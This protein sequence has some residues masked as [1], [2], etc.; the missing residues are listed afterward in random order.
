M[1]RIAVRVTL[2]ATVA[3]LSAAGAAPARNLERVVGRAWEAPWPDGQVPLGHGFPV[4]PGLILTNA[5]TVAACRLLTVE[6]GHG[7]QPGRVVGL[8]ARIDAALVRVASTGGSFAFA[9]APA[10]GEPVTVLTSRAEPAGP[11]ESVQGRTAAGLRNI[12]ASN[13]VEITALLR[14]GD[15]GAPVVSR[16]GA[17]VGMVVGAVS[18]DGARAVIV[19][20]AELRPFL[21]Y[22]GVTSSERGAATAGLG[23][24]VTIT[25]ER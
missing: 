21:A 16:S 18:N 20:A 23:S 10:A 8:D 13:V 25:C 5:H 3:V 15:S 24:V 11:P 7:T 2:A 6:N 19:P 22:Y 17:V 14:P 4:A 1:R 12:Q 9:M